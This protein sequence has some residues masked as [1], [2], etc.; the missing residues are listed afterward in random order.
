MPIAPVIVWFR[1]DLRLSDQPALAAAAASGRP[2]LP[3]YVLDPAADDDFRPGA[4]SRWWL[5]YSLSELARRLAAL[6]GGG[7]GL[8]LRSGPPC[9]ALLE[10][11]RETRAVAVFWNRCLEPAA[12]ATEA[13]LA[14]QLRGLGLEVHAFD[15][16]VLVDPARFRNKSGA[17]YRVFTP[18]WNALARERIAGPAPAPRALPLPPELPR[19]ATLESWQLLPRIDWA[20]GLRA[21]WQPGETGARRRLEAFLARGLQDYRTQRDRPDLPAT[22]RLSPHLHFG[23]IGVREL[24][25]T[26]LRHA[27][28]AGELVGNGFL[29]EVAWREF[30][31]HL[32]YHFPELPERPLRREFGA[33]PWRSDPDALAAW[34]RGRT[35]FPLVDAG[36]REL[37]HTGWMHNRVRMVVGSFLVK[38]LMLPWQS[39]AAWFWDTLVDADLANNSASWQWIAGCGADAAPYFRIFNPVTQSRRFD[40]A[41]AYLRR[42]L[43]ELAR[44]PAHDLHAPWEAPAMVLAA[45][46]VRL[47]VDYPRPIVS[48]DRARHRALEAYEALG[49]AARSWT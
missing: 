44:L 15:G 35:G 11:C 9:E 20:G 37:W 34:Q 47:G 46:G 36:M 10:L 19:T 18:F 14:D 25:H 1:Q 2:V 49:S 23:E 28:G 6:A 48:H 21:A 4:A 27:G 3:V 31:H 13:R 26:V 22:S 32:L 39:G 12:S 24:W 45:A 40:P 43:P 42:W 30:S 7:P 5:H 16:A 38:D 29:R 17:P 41:G 33:F 8:V